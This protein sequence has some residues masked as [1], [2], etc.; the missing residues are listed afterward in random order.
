MQKNTCF[1]VPAF[2]MMEYHFFDSQKK[3]EAKTSE[4]IDTFQEVD[5]GQSNGLKC[6]VVPYDCNLQ[7]Q[8]CKIQQDKLTMG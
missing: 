5:G 2:N 6:N 3:F 1:N 4:N 7:R 8:R